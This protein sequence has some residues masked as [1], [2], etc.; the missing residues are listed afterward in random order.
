MLQKLKKWDQDFEII[1]FQIWYVAQKLD[2]E[3]SY[4]SLYFI[5]ACFKKISWC[6]DL[7]DESE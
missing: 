1:S 4:E 6:S 5:A 2:R 7:R 3:N